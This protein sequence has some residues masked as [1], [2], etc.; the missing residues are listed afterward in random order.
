MKRVCRAFVFALVA[1]AAPCLAA[2]ESPESLGAE[3]HY[4]SG[5]RMGDILTADLGLFGG[6]F[7]AVGLNFLGLGILGADG[8]LSLT[9]R[10]LG[11]ALTELSDI[12]L[13]LGGSPD[14]I[15]LSA[16]GAALWAAESLSNSGYGA[17]SMPSKHFY[18]GK[19][20]LAMYKAYDSYASYRSRS[21]AWDNSKFNRWSFWELFG[22]A[23]DP[24]E[25]ATPQ[26]ILG[27]AEGILA[28]VGTAL[29]TRDDPFGDSVFASGR[30]YEGGNETNA[31]AFA[32][33]SIVN[34]FFSGAYTGVGEEA[35]FR[36][37]LHE[38]LSQRVGRGWATALDSAAFG[39]MHLVT[40]LVRQEDWRY[41]AFHV[42][43]AT[44]TNL[45]LDW[46]YDEGGLRRAVSS[47]AWSDITANLAYDCIFKGVA[48]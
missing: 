34:A 36:G 48:Q 31:T 45:L 11:S 10:M 21:A 15:A 26:V 9:D 7:A 4:L 3:K 41:I 27:A 32:L 2:Q 16:G 13:F 23:L 1:A 46:A 6:G 47:H 8:E 19:N 17:D 25:L 33:D 39:A 22:A 35:V 30:C 18:W 42:S 28:I 38:E 14:A 29:I 20:D 44:L 37:F 40:D 24:K 12:P 5:S 43:S